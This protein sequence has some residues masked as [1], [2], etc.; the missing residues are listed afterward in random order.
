MVHFY[1]IR[2]ILWHLVRTLD[3]SFQLFYISNVFLHL[4][5]SEKTYARSLWSCKYKMAIEKFIPTV[6]KQNKVD[7]WN[8]TNVKFYFSISFQNLMDELTLKGITQYYAFVQEKQKVHCLN[9]LF[10]KLQVCN[11]KLSYISVLWF[12]SSLKYCPWAQ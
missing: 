11:Q 7:M 6:H 8:S 1:L 12:S 5:L 3:S 4:I 9:T 10:S 2:D